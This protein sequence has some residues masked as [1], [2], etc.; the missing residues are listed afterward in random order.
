[1]SE[2]VET[3]T[4][5]VRLRRNWI[6]PT[7]AFIVALL[8]I[9][10]MYAEGDLTL[11]GMM[12][13]WMGG[14]IAP[15][16]LIRNAFQ[17]AR[18]TTLVATERELR[19]G[20]EV[21]PVETIQ[22]ARRVPRAKKKDE[23]VVELK[24]GP[25]KTIAL[26]LRIPDAQRLVN[27]LEVRAGE[28][29]ATF[30]IVL[31]YFVRFLASLLV[32]GLPWFLYRLAEAPDQIPGLIVLLPLG[33]VPVCA[34]IALFLGFIRGKLTVGAEGFTTKWYNVRRLY[35][36]ADV[37]LVGKAAS[38]GGAIVETL[39]HWHGKK[40]RYVVLDAPDTHA[41]RGAESRALADTM[42]QAFSRWKRAPAAAELGTHL[43][44]GQRSAQEWLAG[45]DQLV[46]CGGARYRIAAVTPEALTDLTKAT[47]ATAETRIGAAAALLRMNDPAHRSTVRIAAEACA[48]PRTRMALLELVDAADDEARFT[49]ALSR[50]R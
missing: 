37:T 42:E 32:V 1:M 12:C 27:I 31:P 30:T 18:P 44:R 7:V 24:L 6:V 3:F 26:R 40:L 11:L 20:D 36:F 25:W 19:V 2:R 28:R 49:E 45:I 5:A 46:R 13:L 47:T 35:R 23:T 8:G 29:R 34:V 17:L 21:I 15:L 39:V 14:W 4:D 10:L 33:I 43:V 16:T 50:V 41:D 48:E 22:E 9:A 38:S